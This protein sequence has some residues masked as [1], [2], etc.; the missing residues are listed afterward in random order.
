ML[1][2]QQQRQELVAHRIAHTEKK[3]QAQRKQRQTVVVCTVQK[4]LER[5]QE[6]MGLGRDS[7][8]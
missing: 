8:A 6:M 5:T 4:W 2:Q 3:E 7:R 1:Q